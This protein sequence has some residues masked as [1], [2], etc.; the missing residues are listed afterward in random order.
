MVL[1]HYKRRLF[2]K[3][4]SFLLITCLLVLANSGFSI[5]DFFISPANAQNCMYLGYDQCAT[6]RCHRSCRDSYGEGIGNACEM[7][8]YN[9]CMG[10]CQGLKHQP[11]LV[12]PCDQ[13][14]PQ[15]PPAA[16][17]PPYP[18]APTP[19]AAPGGGGGGGGGGSASGGGSSICALKNKMGKN[20]ARLINCS[21][22]NNMLLYIR[23]QPLPGDARIQPLGAPV[24]TQ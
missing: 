11:G 4:P 9:Q 20:I 17:A 1:T 15:Q 13:P 8:Q 22:Y 16:P 3:R 7:Q 6:I 18:P 14:A 2:R 23:P 19:P 24:H 12:T 21:K 5:R 10:G